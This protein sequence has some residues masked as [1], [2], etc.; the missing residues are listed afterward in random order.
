MEK[1]G[2]HTED[3]PFFIP[4]YEHYNGIVSSWAK[5]LG[6]QIINYTPGTASNGDYTTPDMKN[7]Y[8]SQRIIDNIKAY[9]EKQPN[10][11]NGHFLMIH[12]GTSEARTDKLYYRL[13]EIIELL[14]GR[15]YQFVSVKEM[16]E[17]K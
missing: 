2:I 16:I 3:A 5:Q 15:G 6:L 17:G 12:F 7:Y 8:S 11:L 1:A 13:G 10:G 4:P 9:D 14:Q